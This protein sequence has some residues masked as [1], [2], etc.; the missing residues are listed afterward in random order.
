MKNNDDKL[1]ASTL[2]K[3]AEERLKKASPETNLS[4]TLK[5]IHELQVH[6]I[7]L[8]L[9]NEELILAK[10]SAVENA[11]KYARLYDFAPSGY[12]ALL[13]DGEIIELNLSGAKMLGKDRQS[14]KNKRFGLYVSDDTKPIFN[15]FLEKVFSSKAKESCEV[16]LSINSNL[17]TF[18]HLEG[19]ITEN[20]EQCFLTAIDITE[21]KKAADLLRE[22]EEQTKS[23][24][25]AAQ[26]AI[27]MMNEKGLITFW[28]L[29]AEKIFGY[30]ENEAIGKN[31]HQLL[32]PM[33]Y[34]GE[35]SKAL[36][37]FQHTGQGMAIGKTLELAGIRKNGEEFPIDLSLSSIEIRKSWHAIG[38]V[39][40]I[41]ERKKAEQEL[42]KH[43]DHLKE[44]VKEQTAQLEEKTLLLESTLANIKTLKALLPIC[45]SCKK[46]R[47]DE[48][49]WGQVDTYIASHTDTKFSHSLCPD[50]L[51]K[52]YPD[53]ADEVLEAVSKQE[54]AIKNLK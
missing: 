54:K 39:R 11:D 53:I 50:C 6:Q 16:T 4:G 49:Y 47:D 27:I 29:A 20:A 15:V 2:R 10:S 31:L 13:R 22:S 34:H 36:S 37:H 40:D 14:L 23:I 52:E 26:D 5:L 21:R 1:K 45:S 25:L 42:I 3:K 8:E 32:A 33:R 38:I 44:L 9:Q 43:R 46:I 28:N 7:E 35:H 30:S 24:A 12:F 41:T 51:R 17:P 18:V 19:I 48:G